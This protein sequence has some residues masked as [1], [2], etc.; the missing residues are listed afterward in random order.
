MPTYLWL[1]QSGV[2]CG[3]TI[4]CAERLIQLK[5]GND[6]DQVFQILEGYGVNDSDVAIEEAKLLTEG[7]DVMEWVREY[8]RKQSKENA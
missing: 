1:K 5:P 4:G 6:V 7:I 8:L 2:G 3:Y